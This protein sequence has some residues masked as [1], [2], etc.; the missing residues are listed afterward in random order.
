MNSRKKT[1]CDLSDQVIKNIRVALNLTKTIKEVENWHKHINKIIFIVNKSIINCNKTS[2]LF[3][4][5]SNL[6]ILKFYRE[7]IKQIKSSVKTGS[8]FAKIKRHLVW[9]DLKSVF[10]NRIQTGAIINKGF[11]DPK[12]FFEKA[13]RIFTNKI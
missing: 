9:Q 11:K 10:G 12:I 5:E 1:I 8:G 7:K 4:L 2:N 6:A 3:K 13:V